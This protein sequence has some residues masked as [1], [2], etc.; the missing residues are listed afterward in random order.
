MFGKQL[1]K[2]RK[3][4]NYT[5]RELAIALSSKSEEFAVLD[6]VTISRWERGTTTP[7]NAKAARVLRCLTR[8]ISSFII[9]LFSIELVEDLESFLHER[10][11]SNLCKMMLAAFEVE[12]T[13]STMRIQHSKLFQEVDDH[14]V[15]ML[16]R[17]HERYNSER[18]DLFNLDLYLYQEDYRLYSLRVHPENEIRDVIGHTIA[19]FFDNN[20]ILNDSLNCDIDFKQAIRFREDRE[21]ALY[22]ASSFSSTSKVF[23][24]QWGSF[25]D[26]LARNSNI[27]EMYMNILSGHLAEF[28]IKCGF[29]I[30]GVKNPVD[31]GEIKIG[32]RRYE[33]CVVRV[34]TSVLLTNKI[35][36]KMMEDFLG[37]QA[38]HSG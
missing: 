21:C 3:S 37:G 26:F 1:K 16:R 19:F 23:R 9:S 6:L 28:L 20:D 32:T 7:K 11:E 27:T 29:E 38:R 2:I 12:L 30:V 34:D 36:L 31:I 18:Q 4:N 33:R 5:Q 15:G 10:F 17:F 8:D 13:K 22:V 35:A 14:T 24:Y 25:L